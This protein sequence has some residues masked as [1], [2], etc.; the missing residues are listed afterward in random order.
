MAV[1]IQKSDVSLLFDQ[2]PDL[3]DLAT[4]ERVLRGQGGDVKKAMRYCVNQTRYVTE[5]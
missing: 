4:A 3:A 2:F 5:I 1:S